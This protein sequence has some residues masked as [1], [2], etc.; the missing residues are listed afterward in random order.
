VSAEY[1][2]VLKYSD[3]DSEQKS[4]LSQFDDRR[5]RPS[6]HLNVMCF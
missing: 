6:A 2:T 5:R 1:P 3:V 4:G